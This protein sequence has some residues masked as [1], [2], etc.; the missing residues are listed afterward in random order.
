MIKPDC[1]LLLV[2][3]FGVLA[4]PAQAFDIQSKNVKTLHYEW[5]HSTKAY[6]DAWKAMAD[7]YKDTQYDSAKDY[8]EEPV[9]FYAQYDLNGD[10][11]RE[12]IAKPVEEMHEEGL[13]CAPFS[14]KC[15]HYII[16]AKGN[17]APVLIGKILANA[18]DVDTESTGSYKNLRAYVK[19]DDADLNPKSFGFFET[20]KFDANKKTY[21]NALITPKEKQKQKGAK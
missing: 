12:V 5:E 19:E 11:I 8:V 18:V 2:V 20:Y 16:E 9:I 1:L 6:K 3:G 14:S 13:F 17:A 10:G 21:V 15:P 4:A 7:L